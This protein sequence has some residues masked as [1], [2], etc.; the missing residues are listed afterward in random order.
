MAFENV[1]DA[2]VRAIDTQ[3]ALCQRMGASLSCHGD[4]CSRSFHFPCAAGAGCYQEI[5]KLTLFCPSHLNQVSSLG[6]QVLIII[7]LIIG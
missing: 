5:Q 7:M 2:A 4:G 6:M 1:E 3:C